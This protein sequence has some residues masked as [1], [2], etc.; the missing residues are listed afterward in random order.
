MKVNTLGKTNPNQINKGMEVFLQSPSQ[1]PQETKPK[2][3]KT[4][5]EKE[6][7]GEKMQ[8][9]PQ[10]QPP[11]TNEVKKTT[12]ELIEE[13]EMLESK[14]SNIRSFDLTEFKQFINLKIINYNI[15]L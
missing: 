2:S 4:E 3:P 5:D 13:I 9:K 7:N 10:I 15:I 11:K 14:L 8:I 12:D 1:K 6:I